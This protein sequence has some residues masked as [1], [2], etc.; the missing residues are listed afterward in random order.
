MWYPALKE[1]HLTKAARLATCLEKPRDLINRWIVSRHEELA[2]TEPA[3]DEHEAGSIDPCP[4]AEPPARLLQLQKLR[5]PRPPEPIRSY[6][7][8]QNPRGRA[9]LL[10][11]RRNPRIG[12]KSIRLPP[13]PWLEKKFRPKSIG[14][15]ERR[16]RRQATV[17]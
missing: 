16:K 4:E 3:V 10:Q 15:A 8:Q 13:I 6:D 11:N 2:L 14:I 17:R 12:R 5:K 7:C 9:E 1:G